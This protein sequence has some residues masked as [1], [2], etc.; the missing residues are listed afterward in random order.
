[1]GSLTLISPGVKRPISSTLVATLLR[2]VAFYLGAA[3]LSLLLFTFAFVEQYL[4]GCTTPVF[5]ALGINFFSAAIQ[6]F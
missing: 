1:M 5:I 2:N 3:V 6:S 4:V